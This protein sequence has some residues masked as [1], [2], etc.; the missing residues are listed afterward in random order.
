MDE[1]LGGKNFEVKRT[2]NT[3]LNEDVA[4]INDDESAKNFIQSFEDKRIQFE[5]AINGRDAET[6]KQIA[7][8]FLSSSKKF[9]LE[10]IISIGEELKNK[11]YQ[12][13]S[14]WMY[15]DLKIKQISQIVKEIKRQYS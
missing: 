3:D 6:I 10:R 1:L 13:P 14:D 11:I 7:E 2:V 15:A 12:K 4:K 8:Y 9:N 5:R